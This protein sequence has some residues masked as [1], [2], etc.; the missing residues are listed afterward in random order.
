MMIDT[1]DISPIM[2]TV[3]SVQANRRRKVENVFRIAITAELS[4]H[5]I[6]RPR[7]CCAGQFAREKLSANR[8]SDE[9]QEKAKQCEA[10]HPDSA[11]RPPRP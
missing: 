9:P 4:I 1:M 6:L 7:N 8:L 10:R 3:Q 2:P 5:A 11:N